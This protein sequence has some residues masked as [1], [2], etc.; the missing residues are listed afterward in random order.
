[1]CVADMGLDELY[2]YSPDLGPPDDVWRFWE[3]T[4][5]EYAGSTPKAELDRLSDGRR[6]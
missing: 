2:R 1:V 6:R 5:R 4:L 3:S